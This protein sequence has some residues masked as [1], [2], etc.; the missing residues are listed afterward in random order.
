MSLLSNYSDIIKNSLF[1]KSRKT[2]FWLGV[3]IALF[4]AIFASTINVIGKTLVDPSYG[5]V[6]DAIH[7]LNLAI[8]LG[9]VSGL[10]FTP[11]AKG[12]KSP[13]KFG[14]K[15]LFLV[16]MLGITDVLAV[17][18]NFF[19]LHHTTA[20][21]ATILINTELLFTMIIALTVFRE[22]VEKKEILPLGMIAI[23]AIV[24]PLVIDIFENGNFSSGFV[25]GDM[26][27]IVAAAF[28]A[29]DISIARYVS[30]MVPATRISQISA[31]AGIPFALILVLIFQIQIEIPIEQIPSIIYMG[32]FVSGLSYFFFVIALKLIGAI[33]TVLIYSTTTVFGI[34]FSG[35]FLGEKI[36]E[37]HIFSVAII[38]VGVYL[39]RKKFANLEG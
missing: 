17:T 30:T 6:E 10:F 1:L 38:I 16:L 2:N 12:K 39:L 4:A 29:L 26:M 21:N 22:R 27:I 28:F 8:L 34:L 35:I 25:F 37:I 19:G 14:R 20:V 23:G 9:L 7:P 15:A 31:F 18:T 33:R 11:F 36:T 3:I 13:T 24:L 32:V 5:F